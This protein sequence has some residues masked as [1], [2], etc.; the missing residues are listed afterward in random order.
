MAAGLFGPEEIVVVHSVKR[1]N[2]QLHIGGRERHRT[3]DSGNTERRIELET[4]PGTSDCARAPMTSDAAPTIGSERERNSDSRS[5]GPE[6]V[7][8]NGPGSDGDSTTSAP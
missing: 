2:E 6:K 5:M 3:P 7:G 1:L 8:G 4:I